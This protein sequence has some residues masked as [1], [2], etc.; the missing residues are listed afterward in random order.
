MYIY[1]YIYIYI[2]IYIYIYLYIIYI[3]NI[4]SP[5]NNEHKDCDPPPCRG[6]APC[7]DADH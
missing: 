5:E 3:Y 1:I 7:T 6:L 2:S 4:A